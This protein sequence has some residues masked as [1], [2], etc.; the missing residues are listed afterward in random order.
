M[1]LIYPRLAREKILALGIEG[2]GKTQIALQIIKAVASSDAAKVHVIETDPAWEK[3]LEDPEFEF[4]NDLIANDIVEVHRTRCW[5]DLV[6]AR[7]NKKWV[8]DGI[9]HKVW[10]T[11]DRDDWIIFDNVAF[12]WEWIVEWY[13]EDVLG[14]PKD[15]FMLSMRKAEIEAM[16][17]SIAQ[18]GNIPKSSSGR[19]DFNEYQDFI[20]PLWNR[21]IRSRLLDPPCHLYMTT[22]SKPWNDRFDGSNRELASIYQSFGVK[23]AGQKDVGRLADTVLLLTKLS[24]GKYQMTTVK[25]RGGRTEFNK[26]EWGDF[27]SDYMVEQGWTNKDVHTPSLKPK[28]K[29]KAKK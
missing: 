4:I 3:M 12:P 11:A 15:E 18:A 5:T 28:G 7:K 20:N 13:W 22:W 26:A 29:G 2:T 25:D 6:G 23:P 10:A 21:M 17:E 19:Q 24:S 1:T 14:Q 9:I 27:A 16:E 8:G